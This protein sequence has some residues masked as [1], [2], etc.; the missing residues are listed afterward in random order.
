MAAL[1]VS[2]LLLGSGFLAGYLTAR[3]GADDCLGNLA[4]YRQLRQSGYRF[5]NPLLECDLSEGSLAASELSGLKGKVNAY[6]ERA[7]A[8]GRLG[9]FAIY[10]RQLKDG[11]WFGINPLVNFTPASLMKLPLLIGYLKEAERDPGLLGKRIM[12]DLDSNLVAMQNYP[13]RETIIPGLAYSVD[14]LLFRMVAQ[15]DNN[16]WALLFK[17]IDT[18]KL[19]AI[20]HDMDISY[21]PGRDDDTMTV[22]AY[23]G[24]LRILYNASYLSK[25]MSEKALELLSYEEFPQGIRQGVPQEVVVAGKFGERVGGLNRGMVK[26]LHE[27]AIV[28]HPRFPYLF[29]IMTRGDDFAAL[30]KVIGDVSRIIYTDVDSQ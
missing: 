11:P 21:V 4:S 2:A 28:Y 5:I 18:E 6:L 8:E 24:F 7:R 15:S 20:L 19:N 26:Q 23:S 3:H 30:E 29:G 14:D 10:F 27:F 12:N 25:E 16:A 22:K 1:A 17:N 13:P 9:E